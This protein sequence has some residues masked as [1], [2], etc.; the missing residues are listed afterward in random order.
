LQEAGKLNQFRW[1]Y[2]R[3]SKYSMYILGIALLIAFLIFLH[4]AVPGIEA[5]PLP[6]QA[7]IFGR[8]K[9]V[10]D[11][12][13]V[14]SLTCRRI[15]YPVGIRFLQGSPEIAFVA[16]LYKY[17]AIP[18]VDG[19]ELFL[20]LCIILGALSLIWLVQRYCGNLLA[21]GISALSF[22]ISAFLVGHAST[23]GIYT[24]FLLF[25]FFVSTSLWLFDKSFSYIK[26]LNIWILIT[27]SVVQIIILEFAVLISGYVYTMTITTI[28]IFCLAGLIR[29]IG[30]HLVIWR[31]PLGT[32]HYLSLVGF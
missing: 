13:N 10:A 30:G 3:L 32:R 9:C 20:S 25:P 26:K 6:S 31:P 5:P 14:L 27:L 29:S 28:G 12:G 15:G 1:N 2:Q 18:L 8:A 24:G 16:F 21:A 7:S 11:A 22:Y 17:L 19:T 4:G 23:N